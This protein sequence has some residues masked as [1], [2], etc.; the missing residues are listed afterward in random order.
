MYTPLSIPVAS[1]S[2]LQYTSPRCVVGLQ[3]YQWLPEPRD[4]W[5]NSRDVRISRRYF[6]ILQTLR[7]LKAQD[8]R[9]GL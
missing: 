4:K 2:R 7:W 9:R 8:L 5:G 1:V 6:S 3:R